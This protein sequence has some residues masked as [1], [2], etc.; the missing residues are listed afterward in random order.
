MARILRKFQRQLMITRGDKD[1]EGLLEPETIRRY[2][3]L[4]H[5]SKILWALRAERDALERQLS[6]QEAF[7]FQ[8]ELLKFLKS[9]DRYAIEPRQL[10]DSLAGL[11][12]MNWRQSYVRCSKMPYDSEPHLHFRVL[13]VIREVWN[14]RPKPMLASPAQFFRAKLKGLPKRR[15]YIREFLWKHYR[16]LRLAIDK[17][18]KVSYSSEKWPVEVTRVFL[19]LMSLEKSPAE[20]VLAEGEEIS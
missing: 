10:A 2:T 17:C 13:Q 1:R 16:D 12:T 14:M 15:G 5:D 7:V 4:V 8:F 6:K 19:R 18:S 9:K 3:Q 11:P 20:R